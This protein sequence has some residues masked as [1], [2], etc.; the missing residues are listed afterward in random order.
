MTVS[1]KTRIGKNDPGEWPGLL[2][3]YRRYPLAELIV[4]PRLQKDFYKGTPHREAFS[5][6]SGPWPVVYNG[7][8][9]TTEDAAAL[10]RDF[11]GTDA[12]MLGR[13][14]M[15]DPSLLRQLRGGP[16]ASVRE[17]RTYHDRLLDAYRQ[18]LSGDLPVMHRMWELW[19]YL[20][21]GFDRAEPYLKRM[22]K[23][24]NLSEYQ[25]AVD[26]LLREQPLVYSKEG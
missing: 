20:A 12:V 16:A 4:H 5:T 7:D 3:I 23:A 24:K 13:G 8:I 14:L 22:R 19:T 10:S 17:V 21:A 15:R 9:W 11:P 26:A 1:V 18:R 2:E 6:V 25:A